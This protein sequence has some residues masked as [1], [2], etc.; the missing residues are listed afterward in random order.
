[1]KMLVAREVNDLK[2]K[3][4]NLRAVDLGLFPVFPLGLFFWVESYH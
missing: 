3:A 2:G 1:M 4:S